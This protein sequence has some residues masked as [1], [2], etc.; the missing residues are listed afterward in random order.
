MVISLECLYSCDGSTQYEGVDV[1]GTCVM[2]TY[3]VK[4]SYVVQS[5][6][7]TILLVQRS[8]VLEMGLSN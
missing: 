1:V 7:Q 4:L 8:V 2:I 5:Q 6:S 3:Q